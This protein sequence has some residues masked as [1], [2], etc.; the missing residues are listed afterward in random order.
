MRMFIPAQALRGVFDEDGRPLDAEVGSASFVRWATPRESRL[1]DV[2]F[3]LVH[4]CLRDG[5]V[6]HQ[7]PFAGQ[8][9]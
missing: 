6:H 4:F 5:S 2:L 8:V 9:Q 1:G 3:Q 7:I